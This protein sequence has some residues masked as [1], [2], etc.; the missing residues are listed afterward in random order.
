MAQR[1]FTTVEA[2]K[3]IGVSRQ[4]LQT[5]IAGKMI[6]APMP[7]EVG[8]VKVRLWTKTDI[9]RAKRFTGTLKPGPKAKKRAS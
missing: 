5:W 1:T 2:A 9:D 8:H 4:T 7:I 3:L 6:Q